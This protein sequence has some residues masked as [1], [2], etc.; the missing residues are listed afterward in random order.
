[1]AL[2]EVTVVPLGTSST[3]L[4]AYVAGCLRVLQQAE[5]IK[6]ELTSMGTIMEGDLDRVLSLVRQMH[7]VPFSAGAA[8]VT[9]TVRIDDRRDKAGTMEG[10]VAA[11]KTRLDEW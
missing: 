8:R 10:K 5:G 11:V 3:S 9:T 6:Y 1:M 7:E 4:S 2:V